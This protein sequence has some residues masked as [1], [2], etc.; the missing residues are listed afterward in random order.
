MRTLLLTLLLMA[1]QACSNATIDEANPYDVEAADTPAA[2]AL[3]LANTWTTINSN[4]GA[5]LNAFNTK[6]NLIRAYVMQ[7]SQSQ[8]SCA[9]GDFTVA[10]ACQN[11]FAWIGITSSECANQ[12]CNAVQGYIRQGS[13]SGLQFRAKWYYRV[14]AG[15]AT[16]WE[17]KPE[18]TPQQNP[19]GEQFEAA[20]PQHTLWRYVP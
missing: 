1:A 11:A 12:Q 9:C 13:A 17:L 6:C 7:H 15:T 18:S 19:T 20:F 5:A 10:P 3:T 8:W 16:Y 14:G 4:N 2:E